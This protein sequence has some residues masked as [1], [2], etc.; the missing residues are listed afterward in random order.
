MPRIHVSRPRNL[1]SERAMTRLDE[2]KLKAAGDMPLY[3]KIHAQNVVC[4]PWLP[5][6][7]EGGKIAAVGYKLYLIGGQALTI[8]NDI[9]VF[10]RSTLQWTRA[11][12]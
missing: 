12:F 6:A 10:K 2:L 3:I 7:R 5:P 9:S 11:N 8:T 4:D 1:S